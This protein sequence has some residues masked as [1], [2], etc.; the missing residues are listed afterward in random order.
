MYRNLLL[1]LFVGILLFGCPSN[2]EISP[3]NEAG[4][5]AFPEDGQ[6]EPKV[7]EPD[8]PTEDTDESESPPPE[9]VPAEPDIPDT[10]VSPG[11]G[12]S[13][14]LLGRSV[15]Y[16]WTEYMG[17][18][19]TCD[20]EEC[21]TGSPRGEY[22]GYNFIYY[23]LDYPPEIGNSAGV[24]MDTYGS[25]AGIVFFKLCFA[26]FE[27]D[28][29]GELLARNKRMVED[30]YEEIVTKRGKTMIVG[31]A[32]PMVAQYTEPVLVSDH[33]A[34]NSWLDDF[35]STHEDIYVLD[36]YGILVDSDGA[37]KPEYAVS[38]EDSHLTTAAYEEIT[39]EFFAVVSEVEP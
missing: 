13:I 7:A 27:P 24:G 25:D 4:E 31:N 36:L 28:E 8:V 20:D 11:D 38:S 23:E 6:A 18:E 10:S 22:N 15:T 12:K 35:A 5:G 14:L 2:E 30:A 16:Y 1:V 29:S 17:L 34:Y 21:I 39:P 37:L 19:W 32:L 26:D 9:E 33:L 3:A